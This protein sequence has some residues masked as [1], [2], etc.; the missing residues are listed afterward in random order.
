MK[1]ALIFGTVFL[2][3]IAFS[4]SLSLAITDAASRHDW[5]G[6]GFWTFVLVAALTAIVAVIY[7]RKE[8]EV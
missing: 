3:I 6:V 5:L 4:V 8:P 7:W 1:A 2:V